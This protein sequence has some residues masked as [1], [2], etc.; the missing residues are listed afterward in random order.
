MQI[1][2]ILPYAVSIQ[3]IGRGEKPVKRGF[4][5][6]KRPQKPTNKFLSQL[7]PYIQA[8]IFHVTHP[9]EEV[10]LLLVYDDEIHRI[11]F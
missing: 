4:K 9:G 5:E 8:H 6:Q 11:Y 3:L 10:Q 7:S 2:C 1:F